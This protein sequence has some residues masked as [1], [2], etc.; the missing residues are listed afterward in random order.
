MINNDENYL[1][2]INELLEN[3]KEKEYYINV[4]KGRKRL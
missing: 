2:K 4:N 3:K 1:R